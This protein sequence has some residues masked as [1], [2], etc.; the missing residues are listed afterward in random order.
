[1]PK[2]GAFLLLRASAGFA[3]ASTST[4]FASLALH[5]LGLSFMARHHIGF[6]ALDLVG[7]RHWRLFFTIP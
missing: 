5:D 7:E 6:I 1:M 2:T 4:A 3:F